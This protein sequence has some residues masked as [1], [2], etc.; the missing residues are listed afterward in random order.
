MAKGRKKRRWTF[1]I[2]VLACVLIAAFVAWSYLAPT[3]TSQSVTRYTAYEV[4][5]RDIQT[6]MS[7]GGTVEILHSQAV[8]VS[9]S[10]TVR[11]VY[12]TASQAVSEGDKLLQ[13]E[14]GEVLTATT[15]GV[16]NQ[17]RA[18]AGG[19]AIQGMT[20][21]QICDL[22]HM[23]ITMSV[24]EYD[25]SKL[26]VG[27]PCQI[28]MLSLG[29][30][31]DAEIAH[32]N[33]VSSASGSMAYYTASIELTVPEAVLPGMQ[34]SVTIPQEA[35]AGVPAL[36]VNAV[37]YDAQD[38]PYVYVQQGDGYAAVPVTLGLNDGM[39][40]QIVDGLALGDTAYLQQTVEEAHEGFTLESLYKSIF[41]E[42][43]V[44]NESRRQG[45][46][47]TGSFGISDGASAPDGDADDTDGASAPNREAGGAEMPGGTS[48]DMARPEGATVEAATDEGTPARTAPTN[49]APV[50]EAQDIST[51]EE[52]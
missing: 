34:V 37:S 36:P 8:S 25:I 23:Q 11:E 1:R 22:T 35:V 38:A 52:E 41:G 2:L 24:D 27:Q 46:G 21:V 13:L 42:R 20:L 47:R 15:D 31:F 18:R 28:Y 44:I 48:S 7:F 50:H 45:G 9:E 33:R 49:S 16:V 26:K 40:V 6:A 39:Y 4:E 30:N 32:I 19:W 10:T 17:L 14:N 5:N 43:V 12:V 51:V 29:L 3:L